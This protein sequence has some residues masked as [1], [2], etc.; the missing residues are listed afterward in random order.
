MNTL[1]IECNMGAAGDMLM[2]A[3]SEVHQNPQDFVRRFNDLNIPNVLLTREDCVKCG[4]KGTH[5]R[6]TVNG[7][8]EGKHEHNH[9]DEHAHHHLHNHTNLHSIEHIIQSLDIPEKVKRDAIAV[10][11]LIAEAE[12]HVH[13]MPIRD[14]HFHEVGTMDAVADVVGVCMLIHEL[15][16][17]KIVVSPINVGRGTVKCAHGILPV[18]APATAYILKDM[19]IYSGEIESELCTP[20]GAALLKY[21]ADEF[22]NMPFMKVKNIG[23]GM[24]NKDFTTANCVRVLSGIQEDKA[25]E[26]IELVCNLDDITSEDIGFAVEILISNGALD[27]YTTPIFMKKNR[28][29]YMLTCM[30]RKEEREKFVHLILKHT[31]T[32]GVREYV[33]NRYCL[34]RAAEVRNTKYGDVR[35]KKS[36]G[37]GIA[38]EK[39]EYEDLARIANE[40]NMSV[41]AVRKQLNR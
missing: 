34:D 17:D 12:G 6:V 36:T 33:C 28:P 20:T 1:F 19:P 29:A 24:G 5:M 10:Y 11:H 18:P 31:T 32:L 38:R 2:A 23:H 37:F 21:F 35:V 4:I 39:M 7:V 14:I 27:V 25:D 16:P 3:L 41:E 22:A 30:C 40:N 13:G 15:A 8:E 9:F 26:V